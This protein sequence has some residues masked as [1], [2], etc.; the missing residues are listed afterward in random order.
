MTWTNKQLNERRK[1]KSWWN[2]TICCEFASYTWAFFHPKRK[3]KKKER[4]SRTKTKNWLEYT[5]R[6]LE[7]CRREFNSGSELLETSKHVENPPM[8][9]RNGIWCC[10]CCC[11]CDSHFF[12][13]VTNANWPFRPSIRVACRFSLYFTAQQNNRRVA[14]FCSAAQMKWTTLTI[15][16]VSMKM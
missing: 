14:Q 5:F 11:C 6:C 3:K 9:K 2:D 4:S 13:V 7:K 8:H 10:C 12:I 1:K 15:L 16:A